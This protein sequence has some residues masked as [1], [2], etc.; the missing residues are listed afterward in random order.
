[1]LRIRKQSFLEKC[2]FHYIKT[3]FKEFPRVMEQHEGVQFTRF[4]NS[5]EIAEH[6][7]SMILFCLLIMT[8]KY[9]QVNEFSE[10]AVE[11]KISFVYLYTSRL[12]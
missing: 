12:K 4:Q 10:F 9:S 8:S 2:L 6:L 1:M 7:N 3:T 11:S 5:F